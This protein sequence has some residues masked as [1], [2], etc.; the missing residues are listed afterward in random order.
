MYLDGWHGLAVSAVLRAIAEDPPPPLKNKFDK[1]IHVD[2]SRWKSRRAVQME[3][4]DQL[5]LSQRTM[6]IFA[7]QDEEDDYSGVDEGSRL[8]IEAVG[9]EIHRVL[10]GRIW[11]MVFHNGSDSTVDVHHFGIPEPRWAAF[12]SKVLWTFRGR[13]RLNEQISDNVDKSHYHTEIGFSYEPDYLKLLAEEAREIASYTNKAC[14]TPEI[15][16][17]CCLYLL[18]LNSKGGSIVSYNWATHASNYWVCDGIIEGGQEDRAWNDSVTLSQEIKLEDYSF[19]TLPEFGKDLKTPQERWMFA[20]NEAGEKKNVPQTSTS[21]FLANSIVSSYMFLHARK[22]RV[23]KLCRCSFSFSTPP[24]YFCNSLRFLGLDNCQNEEQIGEGKKGD[25]PTQNQAQIGEDEKQDSA[26]MDFFQSLWVLDI[27]CTDWTLSANAVD[28]MS[29]NIREVNVRKGR[30]WGHQNL[31]WG[32]LRNLRN[33]RVTEPISSWETGHKDEFIG[34]VKLELLDLSGNQTIRVLPSLSGATG[35]KTLVLDFCVRLQ[36]VGPEGFLPKSL[37]SFSFDAGSDQKSEAKIFK[38]CLAGCIHLRNI[39]LRGALPHLEELDLS[40]TRVRKLDLSE[41]VVQVPRLERVFLISCKQL[42]AIMWCNGHKKLKVLCIDTHGE[43]VRDPPGPDSSLYPCNHQHMI[44]NANAV[45]GDIRLIQSLF[46]HGMLRTE[47][48]YLNLNNKPASSSKAKVRSSGKADI[49]Q[50]FYEHVAV[51]QTMNSGADMLLEGFATHDD[52]PWPMPLGLHVDIGD[53]IRLTDVE[54]TSAIEA[55]HNYLVHHTHSLHVHD[56]A[57]ITTILPKS[58]FHAGTYSSGHAVFFK[59]CRIERCPELR[60]VFV[61]DHDMLSY[62]FNWLETI[63]VA[64]LLKAICIWSKGIHDRYFVRLQSI[65]LYSCP[66]LKF[67][68]RISGLDFSLPCLEILHV[69]SCG[70]IRI[71]FPTYEKPSSEEVAAGVKHQ[72]IMVFPKL[73]R[74]HL[75]ELH[76]LQHICEIKMLAPSLENVM[77][78]G[79]SGLRRLPAVGQDRHPIVNCEKDLWERL[80]WDGLDAGH[81]PSLY[82]LHHSANYRE[83]KLPR[84]TVLR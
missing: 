29:T 81:H 82:Q 8:E 75:Y 3:I 71:M 72:G 6:S 84:G 46:Q 49:G 7:R 74:I 15:A 17:E 2:C 9:A 28:K 50:Y 64:H 54:N 13:L 62:A 45:T 37:E 61:S 1:I 21:F 34:M 83:D 33:L 40:R 16:T 32:R 18:S 4:A 55:I 79:C 43:E 36:Q 25:G 11:L 56:N 60:E 14:I 12:G 42:R 38:I 65:Y 26:N 31:A 73:K 66:R 51:G 30:I 20:T 41:M 10:Q 68:K 27:Q 77:L 76:S 19:N 5:K 48:S 80:E 44:Y 70:D 39:K 23:L 47:S 58:V 69:V 67:I 22:L 57:S 78:R 24:F 59:W 53:G 35:L 52:I 63:L